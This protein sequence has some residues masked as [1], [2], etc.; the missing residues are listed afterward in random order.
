MSGSALLGSQATSSSFV[1]NFLLPDLQNTNVYLAPMLI[2][3]RVYSMRP[4]TRVYGYFDNTPISNLCT[5][6]NN[7]ITDS[8]SPTGSEGSNLVTSSTGIISFTIRVPKNTFYSRKSFIRILD[9]STLTEILNTTTG[10]IG[11][12]NGNGQLAFEPAS[13]ST[14][15]LST[16]TEVNI[17]KNSIVSSYNEAAP[18]SLQSGTDPY[19]FNISKITNIKPNSA[20]IYIGG[21]EI[22]EQ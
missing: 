16:A 6:C 7:S 22:D 14:K 2:N 21:F 19:Y 4:N 9:V 12:F 1:R 11:T 17:D 10:A 5:P 8:F 13:N 15:A 20:S 3:V 18:S